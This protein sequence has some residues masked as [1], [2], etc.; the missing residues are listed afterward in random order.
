MIKK[1]LPGPDKVGGVVP[2]SVCT[3]VVSSRTTVVSVVAARAAPSTLLCLPVVNPGSADSNAGG[4]PIS[5]TKGDPPD[6]L[7]NS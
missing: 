5:S 6:H 2:T 1:S 3:G 4:V 7:H